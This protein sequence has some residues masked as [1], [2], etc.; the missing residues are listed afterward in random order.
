MNIAREDVYSIPHREGGDNGLFA[1]L[2]PKVYN[3]VFLFVGLIT[4]SLR[5]LSKFLLV[6][7]LSWVFKHFNH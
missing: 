1:T 5:D 2:V 6:G 4:L 7:S 3:N